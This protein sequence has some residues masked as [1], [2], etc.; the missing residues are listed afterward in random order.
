V[1]FSR[2]GGAP[3][4]S[5]LPSADVI[6][7]PH[8]SFEFQHL[9]SVF[10]LQNPAKRASRNPQDLR[11]PEMNGA[12]AGDRSLKAALRDERRH[13]Q[14]ERR[15]DDA[16][17]EPVCNKLSRDL[18]NNDPSGKVAEDETRHGDCGEEDRIATRLVRS[19]AG[20][21]TE[22]RANRHQHRDQRKL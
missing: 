11:A 13:H 21:C 17:E 8:D 7:N 10:P 9:D 12:V 18:A 20:R 19:E 15:R 1:A 14:V 3:R 6:R 2:G 4:S 16:D 5:G 22:D